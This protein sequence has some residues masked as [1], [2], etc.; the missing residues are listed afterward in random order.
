MKLLESWYEA[1]AKRQNRPALVGNLTADVCVIGGGLAGLTT[2]RECQARG[3]SSVLLDASR[4]A[5]AASGRNGGFVFNGFAKD[6]EAI[7]ARLG[8]TAARALYD[9]SRRGTEY[10]R[11][12]IATHDPS[13]QHGEGLRIVLRHSDA[14]G[15][16]KHAN[17]LR[18]KLAET[19]EVL[20]PEQ[21]RQQLDSQRYW[22]SLYF[23]QAFHIHPLRYA[24]LLA[25]QAEGQGARLFENTPVLSVEKNAAGFSVN[26]AKGRVVAKHVVHC[27][28]SLAPGLHR[29]SGR[30]VLPVATYV[31]VTEATPQVAIR[32][33]AAVADTRRAGNYYRLLPDGRILWGGRITTR[34]SEPA[35][36]A[37]EMR[38]D[39]VSVF[40]QLEGLRMQ[41]A[42]SGIMCR[43]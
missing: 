1:T 22:Q 34:L 42:W 29:H 20:S 3:L 10:V 35:R 31:A 27:T 24:L 32:T 2:L 43:A 30:A 11:Q 33:S 16:A 28:S 25:D 40:P 17:L 36:L 37:E 21:T 39:M 6:T 14:Q 9:Q 23:P 18:E 12:T 4:L 38:R 19:V 15:L 41:Y 7:A 8:W 13:I 5:S 26:T